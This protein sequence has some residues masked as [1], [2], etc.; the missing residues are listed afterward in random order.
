MNLL[1]AFSKL[2][3]WVTDGPFH[4]FAIMAGSSLPKPCCPRPSFWKGRVGSFCKCPCG[5]DLR[6]LWLR[7]CAQLAQSHGD[8][9]N[10][11][12][13]QVPVLETA[14]TNW[15]KDKFVT[16]GCKR[17]SCGK[18]IGQPLNQENRS[19]RGKT[20]CREALPICLPAARETRSPRKDNPK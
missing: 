9:S 8:R 2:F 20:H 5:V 7:V 6:L 1:A 11:R 4:P 18:R 15:S 16:D 14:R 10:F 19:C 3:F 13:T 17:Y 12:D